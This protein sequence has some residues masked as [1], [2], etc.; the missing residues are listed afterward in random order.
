[1]GLQLSDVFQSS[2]EYEDSGIL[3]SLSFF[4]I[5]P[6]KLF[7][8]SGFD[9]EITD[10]WIIPQSLEVNQPLLQGRK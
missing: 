7:Y 10:Y 9:A 2:H 6:F 3:P 5:S 8:N 1:M 4:L